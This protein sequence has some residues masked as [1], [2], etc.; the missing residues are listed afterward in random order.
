MGMGN[1][2]KL[3]FRFPVKFWNDDPLFGY[4]R[5]IHKDMDTQHDK[6][7][8]DDNNTVNATMDT[9][10]TTTATAATAATTATTATTTTTT[11]TTANNDTGNNNNENAKGE[12]QEPEKSGSEKKEREDETTNSSE[13]KTASKSSHKI[14]CRVKNDR[15]RF[16][17]WWNLAKITGQPIL[18]TLCAGD[19]AGITE[20][21]TDNVLIQEAMEVL[22]KI[23]G[24]HIPEP[25]S[26]EKS[27]WGTD[28]FSRGCYHYHKK[29]CDGRA[30]F[31]QLKFQFAT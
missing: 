14:L 18:V 26:F 16:F 10:T 13:H 1:L 9:T 8:A 3:V 24:K 25:V 29:G 17:M 27:R 20:L 6:A 21:Q 31:V 11:T 2:N 30:S 5:P 4:A 22:R 12:T 23:F 28:Y 19:E 7:N 15:G